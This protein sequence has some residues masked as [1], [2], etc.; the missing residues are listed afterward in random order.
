MS[1][2]AYDLISVKAYSKPDDVGEF[3]ILTLTTPTDTLQRNKQMEWES[4]RARRVTFKHI[5]TALIQILEATTDIAYHAGNTAMAGLGFRKQTPAEVL[6]QLQKQYGQLSYTK[7]DQAMTR[8]Q[9]SMD[10]VQPIKVMLRQIEEVQM[11]L[12]ANPEE[13]REHSDFTLIQYALIKLSKTGG[14]T[15]MCWRNGTRN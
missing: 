3:C 9:E 8:L 13:G 15:Q 14:C 10:R 5:C 2:K 12:L 1:A 4:K 6:Q 11:F 7:I